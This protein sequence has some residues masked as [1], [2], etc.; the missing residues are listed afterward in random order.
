MQTAA[1]TASQTTAN[2]KFNPYI[3]PYCESEQKHWVT[4]ATTET[5]AQKLEKPQKLQLRN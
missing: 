5:T 4:T 1:A 2:K 3:E